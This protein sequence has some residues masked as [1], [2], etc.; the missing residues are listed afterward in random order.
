M[1]RVITDDSPAAKLQ[2]LWLLLILGK[3]SD[4]LHKS[5]CQCKITCVRV[6]RGV[7]RGGI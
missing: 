5:M 7:S 1:I 3:K 4:S 6:D 2:F